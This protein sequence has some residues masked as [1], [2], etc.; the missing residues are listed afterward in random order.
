MRVL[1]VVGF[2]RHACRTPS[3]K[4]DLEVGHISKTLTCF[5]ETD[6]VSLV[7]RHP[8]RQSKFD[9]GFLCIVGINS[10]LQRRYGQHGT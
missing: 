8:D 10:H 1:D 6:N 9:G 7:L 3:G 4:N 2:F 5:P